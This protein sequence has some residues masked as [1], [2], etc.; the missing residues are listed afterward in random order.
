LLVEKYINR[1][2]YLRVMK[3][4]GKTRNRVAGA[5]LVAALAMGALS[6]FTSPNTEPTGTEMAPIER[7][8]KAP[9]RTA[10]RAVV[11]ASQAPIEYVA[12]SL[13][14]LMDNSDSIDPK[15][16]EDFQ[17][18]VESFAQ[19]EAFIVETD[20]E[21]TQVQ[22]D[23]TEKVSPQSY[24]DDVRNLLTSRREKA[25]AELVTGE[26][27][28]KERG[29][30]ADAIY[31]LASARDHTEGDVPIYD[32]HVSAFCR[33]NG[34]AEESAQ[35]ITHVIHGENHSKL[36]FEGGYRGEYP[37]MALDL[38]GGVEEGGTSYTVNFSLG[39]GTNAFD[40]SG[41]FDLVVE[42]QDNTIDLSVTGEGISGTRDGI[43]MD[44]DDAADQYRSFVGDFYGNRSK[45]EFLDQ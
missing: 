14:G 19:Y 31:A 12:P 21:E 32:S 1:N 22:E 11:P 28:K 29:C 26:A 17:N 36:G 41:Y 45:A 5:G 20:K 42:T 25:C 8:V 38:E 16:K 15:Y 33:E 13:E 24:S 39:N 7:R 6:Y 30:K 4:E 23:G 3:M 44:E 40:E 35:N 10:P 37:T 9:T 18:C 43:E 27:N 2:D 34:P